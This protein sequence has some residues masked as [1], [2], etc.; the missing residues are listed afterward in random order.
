MSHA[1]TLR[2]WAGQ[3]IT[4]AAREPFLAGADALEAIDRV[5]NALNGITRVRA[6]SEY[7]RDHGYDNPEWH[8]ATADAL[9]YV[10]DLLTEA[11][12]GDTD[13]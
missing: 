7:A 5:R 4:P 1:D 8:E 2:T 6:D 9:E 10:I 11:L 13:E 3:Y 12:E